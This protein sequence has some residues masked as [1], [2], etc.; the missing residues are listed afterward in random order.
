MID[1]NVKFED[2]RLNDAVGQGS[3]GPIANSQEQRAKSYR[4]DTKKTKKH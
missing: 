4:L 2:P 1:E 3:Q